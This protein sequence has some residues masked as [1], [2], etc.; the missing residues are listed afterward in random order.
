MKKLVL[1]LLFI[2]SLCACGRLPEK[3]E[4]TRSTEQAGES[5]ST[6]ETTEVVETT[7][8]S[9]EQ[10]LSFDADYKRAHFYKDKTTEIIRTVSELK[11]YFEQNEHDRETVYQKY[12]EE[13]F[14]ENALIIVIPGGM[15]GSYFNRVDQVRVDGNDV[16]IE[17]SRIHEVWE[18]FSEKEKEAF[19]S[20]G[21]QLS[22]SAD[23]VYWGIFVEVDRECVETVDEVLVECVTVPSY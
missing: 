1:L 20:S 6:S 2:F 23:S 11:E 7:V 5:L 10:E 3:E 17:V 14:T 12:N 22:T 18:A 9:S 21:K 19:L 8:F 16:Q 13:W 4:T 15:S